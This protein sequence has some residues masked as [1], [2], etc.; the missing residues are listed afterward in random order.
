MIRFQSECV[1]FLLS[2]GIVAAGCATQRMDP[3]EDD[4]ADLPAVDGDDATSAE[5][6]VQVVPRWFDA[7]SP[8]DLPAID[9]FE[10][11]ADSAGPDGSPPRDVADVPPPEDR[12]MVDERPDWT[13]DV[14]D[15]PSDV[16]VS[17]TCGPRSA[18]CGA[19]CTT[20]TEDPANCGAC[21]VTCAPG[22]RCTLGRCITP[23]R[24]YLWYLPTRAS[25]WQSWTMPA[26]VSRRPPNAPRSDVRA[27]VDVEAT[28]QL[29]V[30]TDT[31]WHMMLLSSHAWVSSG[32]RRTLL[33]SLEGDTIVTAFSAPDRTHVPPVEESVT[34]IVRGV[35]GQVEHA[36]Y[37]LEIASGA[38]RASS[39]GAEGPDWQY[40]GSP[41]RFANV[42][43]AWLDLENADGW[44]PTPT[45]CGDA[46]VNVGPYLGIVAA[47]PADRFGPA[48]YLENVGT[49]ADRIGTWI[50]SPVPTAA[51]APFRAS[52]G[53]PPSAAGVGA[54]FY[55]HGL[56]AIGP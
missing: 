24:T 45:A 56:W 9:A 3:N 18:R 19:I 39:H 7:Q 29:L 26:D 11:A 17:T 37:T 21:G 43:H 20:L 33:P 2:A 35:M 23:E 28:G 46:S 16:A 4:D 36:T 10:V 34:F 13:V 52:P 31:T 50:G 15:V 27:A 30:F 12:G 47:G 6:D 41:G 32:A 44:V 40:P 25:V 14:P 51:F 49:C 55:H 38:L 54:L 22:M 42:L 53:G 48:V 8:S 1:V 5:G